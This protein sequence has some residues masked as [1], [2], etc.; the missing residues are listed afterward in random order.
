VE[1][2]STSFWALAPFAKLSFGLKPIQGLTFEPPAKAGG[3]SWRSSLKVKIG[4]FKKL[5]QLESIHE[6]LI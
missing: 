6:R 1:E 5:H 3:N 4:Y 2:V